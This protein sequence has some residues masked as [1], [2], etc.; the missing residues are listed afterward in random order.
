M[1]KAF[2]ES[3]LERVKQQAKAEDYQIFDL[4]LLKKFPVAEVAG[5][6]GVKRARV[7]VATYKISALLKQELRNSETQQR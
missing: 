3:A 7:Y 6:L 5:Q 1:G 4:H 2:V